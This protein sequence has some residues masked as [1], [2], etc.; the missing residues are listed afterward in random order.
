ML[1]RRKAIEKYEQYLG[2]INQSKVYLNYMKVLFKH[3]NNNKLT[4]FSLSKEQLLTFLQKYSINSKNL[5]LKAIKSYCDYFNVKTQLTEI[6]NIRPDTKIQDY[7]AVAEINN[8]LPEFEDKE[9][10]IVDFLMATGLRAN[11]FLKMKRGDIDLNKGIAKVVFGKGRKQRLIAFPQSVAKEVSR[12][13]DQEPESINAF[14][15]SLGKLRGLCKKMTEKLQVKIT[16]HSLRHV[17][18]KNLYHKGLDLV[19]VSRLLGHSN[20][21]TTQ[22]YLNETSEKV[23]EHYNEVMG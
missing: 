10:V 23:I 1:S 13:F 18:A 2:Q 15:Y 20:I 7:P 11:E 5:F 8:I 16:P 6:K 4:L 14:N 19:S 9:K 17:M 12:L 21:S 3:L 22:I